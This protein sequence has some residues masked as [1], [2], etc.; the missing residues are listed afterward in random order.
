MEG[1]RSGAGEGRRID[2][3]SPAAVSPH[4]SYRSAPLAL[5]PLPQPPTLTQHL[6]LYFLSILIF[7][8]TFF[9]R[10]FFFPMLGGSG[11]ARALGA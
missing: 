4:C 7:C 5:T 9:L 11:W 3:F 6:S 1:A 2:G 10:I 8:S